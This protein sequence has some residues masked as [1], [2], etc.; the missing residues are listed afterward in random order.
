MANGAGPMSTGNFYDR[1]TYA[2]GHAH[3]YSFGDRASYAVLGAYCHGDPRCDAVALAIYAH[4]YALERDA[5]GRPNRGDATR[6]D[7]T[8]QP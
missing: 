2:D 5:A 7:S 3:T 6:G 8:D 4:G 1:V